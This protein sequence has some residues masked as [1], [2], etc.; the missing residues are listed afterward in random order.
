MT[1]VERLE[2]YEEKLRDAHGPPEEGIITVSGLAWV[3]S[4]T[5]AEIVSEELDM[6]LVTSGGFFRREAEKKGL[7]LTEFFEKHRNP[8]KG[9]GPDLMW[10][11]RVLGLAFTRSDV[12]LEGRMTGI[13]LSDIAE[14]RVL[15]KCD[16]GV[17]AERMAEEQE[18]D[19][20]EAR[21]KLE[22]RN[23]Q[24]IKTYKE[25]YGVDVTDEKHYTVVVDNSGPLKETREKTLKKVREKLEN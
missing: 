12:V 11:R 2:S 14:V 13:L 6:D 5:V 16:N 17:A 8:E 24:D 21:K 1:G 10:D 15:V 22:R 20:D 25:K 19:L 7:E 3:G 4:T 18:I 9:P 23:S